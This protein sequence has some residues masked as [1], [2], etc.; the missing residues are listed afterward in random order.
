MNKIWIIIKREYLIRVRKRSFIILT[1]LGPIL[2]A[3]IIIAP[4]YFTSLQEHKVRTIAVIDQTGIYD[5]TLIN[6]TLLTNLRLKN[7][8]ADIKQALYRRLPDTKY[9]KFEFLPSNISIDTIQKNFHNTDFYAVLFIPKNLVASNRIQLYSDKDVALNIKM[10]LSNFF[11]KELE[12]QKLKAK[13]IDPDI[14]KSVNTKIHIDTIKWTKEGEVK[15][16]ASGIAMFLGFIASFFIYF[17]IFMFSSQVIRGVIEEKTNRIIEIIVSSVKPFHL[18]TGKIIG[19]ALVGLTQFLLWI[20][21][22]FAITSMVGSSSLF[23]KNITQKNKAITTLLN[24]TTKEDNIEVLQPVAEEEND[25]SEFGQEMSIALG[26]IDWTV[27]ILSF[28]IFFLGGYFLY[29]SLF[30]AIGSVVD[31]E[32]DTQQFVLP[33]TVPMLIAIVMLQSFISYPDS[34][35]TFWFSMFPFTSPIAMMARIPFGVPIWQILLSIAILIVTIYFTILFSAKIYRIG[36]FMYGKKPS[37]KDL[38]KWM[39]YKI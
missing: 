22:T 13:N 8:K 5:D 25:L 18:M 23:T 9:I 35:V 11:E 34:Q 24:D 37:Y 26:T 28:L 32:T 29:S 20:I 14:L 33:V 36:I 3:A 4:V 30:A 39:K 16:F 12:N 21:L 1:L 31:N 10:Y 7:K 19:V 27:V 15:S 2:L 6:T 17:L 38:M